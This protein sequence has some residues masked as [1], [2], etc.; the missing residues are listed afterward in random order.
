MQYILNENEMRVFS[1]LREENAKLTHKLAVARNVSEADRCQINALSGLVAQGKQ[2][3]K[4]RDERIEALRKV[5]AEF[6]GTLAAR[7]CIIHSLE[8]EVEVLRKD[9]DCVRMNNSS[10]LNTIHNLEQEVHNLREEHVYI[11]TKPN[12][13]TRV[14]SAAKVDI[15]RIFGWTISEGYPIIR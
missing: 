2:S 12:G 11:A 1:S 15:C 3:I 6:E 10:N 13:L 7:E 8:Q 14:I 4:E 5:N 9:L